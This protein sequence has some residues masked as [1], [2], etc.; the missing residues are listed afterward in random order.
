[1]LTIISSLSLSLLTK[2]DGAKRPI[3]SSLGC[4]EVAFRNR[5]C[6][7][8][9]GYVREP[10]KVCKYE[11]CGYLAPKEQ[12]YCKRHQ[13]PSSFA[14]LPITT[15]ANSDPLMIPPK[16]EKK[17]KVEKKK[18]KMCSHNGCDFIVTA[19]GGQFCAKH[20]PP[21]V[22]EH[23]GCDFIATSMRGQFCAKHEPPP[24]VCKHEDCDFIAITHSG[25]CK[26]HN[27]K[28]QA[29]KICSQAE[30]DNVAKLEY[31][32]FCSEWCKGSA[33]REA[34]NEEINESMGE[35]EV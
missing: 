19:K 10:K 31:G 8:H 20:K 15:I 24:P 5:L 6:N 17:K 13:P 28:K 2:I 25:F 7:F 1:M 26:K 21:P 33:D 9:G 29:Q 23:E 12:D 14:E 11:S 22:C 27:P 32:G 34:A 3:C 16:K 35:N 4:N 18:K 30:C